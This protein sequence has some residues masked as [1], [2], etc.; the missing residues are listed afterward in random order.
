VVHRENR[1][2]GDGLNIAA[3]I[4]PL[5]EADGNCLSEDVAREVQNKLEL[6]LR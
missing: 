3:R 4:E 1:V 2:H 6:P 5:A